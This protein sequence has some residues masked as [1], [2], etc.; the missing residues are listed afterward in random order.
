MEWTNELVLE[1]IQLYEKYPVLWNVKDSSHKN[2]NLLNDA[3]QNIAAE[4]SGKMSVAQLKKK[5]ESLMSTYR[6][7]KKK[8]FETDS[9]G[10]GTGDVY[11][12]TWFAYDAINRF[13]R[14]TGQKRASMSTEVN[15][16]HNY[17]I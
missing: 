16:I 17:Y 3:W 14:A 9:S 4:F 13:L 8:V 7:C 6:A 12:P 2:R 10:A 11:T 5:K 15:L 1:F